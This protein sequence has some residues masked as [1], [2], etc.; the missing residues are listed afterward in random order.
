[1]TAEKNKT[2]AMPLRPDLV[3]NSVQLVKIDR[4]DEMKIESRLF[5]APNVILGAET[6]K[7][8]CLEWLL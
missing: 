1:L 7:G 4:F 6:S 3:K 5:G 8:H 2:H